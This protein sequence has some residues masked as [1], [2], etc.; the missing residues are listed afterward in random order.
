[1]RRKLGDLGLHFD[2]FPVGD[3]VWGGCKVRFVSSELMFN[4]TSLSDS[5]LE[6]MRALVVCTVISES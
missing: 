3:V 1:M 5:S 2:S 6:S 4:G